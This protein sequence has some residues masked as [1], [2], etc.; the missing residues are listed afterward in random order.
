VI[1]HAVEYVNGSVHTNTMENFWS[2]LK[3]GLHGTYISVEP[4]H[5]FRYIDEQ[6]FR[7]NN[8]NATDA[9]RFTAVMKQIVG[10]RVT[11]KQLTGKPEDGRSNL[12][13]GNGRDAEGDSV[14]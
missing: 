10:R 4:F 14:S 1:D 5:L 7:Y 12:L 13:P 2:L 3:R 6:A 11:Y 8:R 9:E